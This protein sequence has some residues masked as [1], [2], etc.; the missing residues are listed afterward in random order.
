MKKQIIVI[1]GISIYNLPL[2][3]M[4]SMSSLGASLVMTAYFYYRKNEN[5][6]N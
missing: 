4:N 2:I 5:Q 1:H 3:F 6:R